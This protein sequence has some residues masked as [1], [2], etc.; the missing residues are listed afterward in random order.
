MANL[1]DDE[2]VAEPAIVDPEGEEEDPG[3]EL[4]IFEEPDAI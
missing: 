3:P 2:E 1:Y 4:T